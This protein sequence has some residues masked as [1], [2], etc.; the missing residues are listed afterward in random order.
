M[1][2][3][4]QLRNLFFFPFTESWVVEGFALLNIRPLRVV[5]IV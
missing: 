4:R 2:K 3:N 1:E 5:K